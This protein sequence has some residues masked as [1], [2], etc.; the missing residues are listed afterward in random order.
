MTSVSFGFVSLSL[1]E[2]MYCLV[3]R[4]ARSDRRANRGRG[5]NQGQEN[6]DAPEGE[7]AEQAPGQ[8]LP[9]DVAKPKR[10][11]E[12]REPRNR[13][14]GSRGA[15]REPR[16]PRDREWGASG[17]VA[18]VP[19]GG[20][21]AQAAQQ[22]PRDAAN[23]TPR[24]ILLPPPPPPPPAPVSARMGGAED[25]A[26][27]A[28]EAVVGAAGV[29]EAGLYDVWGA[30]LSKDM[31][32]PLPGD[33]LRDPPVNHPV[34][35]S[36]LAFS[37][38]LDPVAPPASK[39]GS[40]TVDRPGSAKVVGQ[41]RPRSA[42]ANPVG[43]SALP[44][45][46]AALPS[47]ILHLDPAPAPGSGGIGGF[48]FGGSAASQAGFPSGLFPPVWPPAPPAGGPGG[49]SQQ[50]LG[51]SGSFYEISPLFGGSGGGEAARSNLQQ[52][53]V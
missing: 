4:R 15:N 18:A 26:T 10:Q 51:S 27:G 12:P 41:A 16:E 11:R 9:A 33:L 36:P 42:N 6:G 49:N 31:A 43:E 1:Q 52:M 35:P 8:E 13:P 28:A 25:I 14:D 5:R 7:W 3:A 29:S 45:G 17:K 37:A 23:P 38:A 20:R 40:E 22:T 46:I 21:G 47:D 39:L 48:P 50:G 34:A 32:P 24:R 44:N 30:R 53:Q 2:L 19:G